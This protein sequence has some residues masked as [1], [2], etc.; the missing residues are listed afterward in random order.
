MVDVGLGIHDTC[1]LVVLKASLADCCSLLV[2]AD[3]VSSPR[4]PRRNG[5]YR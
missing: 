3:E 1:G 4:R 2:G 5:L